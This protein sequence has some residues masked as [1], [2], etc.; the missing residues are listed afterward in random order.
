MVRKVAFLTSL[1]ALLLLSWF[2][3]RE[4]QRSVC[5]N[6]KLVKKI[7]IESGEGIKEVFACP[8]RSR[9]SLSR[10]AQKR[11]REISA[12]T[13]NLDKMLPAAAKGERFD[14]LVSL[15]RPVR[16]D[17]D[18]GQITVGRDLFW[19][20]GQ[21]ERAIIK[22]VLMQ[23][24]HANLQKNLFY[25]E[26]IVDLLWTII[27]GAPTSQDPIFQEE[28]ADLGPKWIHYLRS[29]KSVCRSKDRPLGLIS[30]C[31]AYE[32]LAEEDAEFSRNILEGASPWGFRPFLRKVF[33]Q[34]FS[35]RPMREMVPFWRHWV[36]SLLNKNWPRAH[37][38]VL[39]DLEDVQGFL[40][41][42]LEETLKGLDSSLGFEFQSLLEELEVAPG[43]KIKVPF[44]LTFDP[45]DQSI[46]EWARQSTR[47]RAR[48]KSSLFLA[49]SGDQLFVF[50]TLFPVKVEGA[51]GLLAPQKTARQGCGPWSVAELLSQSSIEAKI[52]LVEKCDRKI[53]PD[54]VSFISEG[55]GAFSQVNPQIAFWS[56]N[57]RSLKMGLEWG[58]KESDHFVFTGVNRKLTKV[59]KLMGFDRPAYDSDRN[60][61]KIS[62][63]LPVIDWYRATSGRKP[64]LMRSKSL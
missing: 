55:L 54:Y 42:T 44:L 41:V 4:S 59:E 29:H 18:R 15:R 28:T 27:S 3:G 53:F 39:K 13:S 52:L 50:P 7:Q 30:T 60:A 9:E 34:V 43:Q 31:E 1:F 64:L 48:D 17:V 36:D 22:R 47:L 10:A 57:M 12:F 16:L 19:L 11:M 56:L 35:E 25:Q 49:Y 37:W 5:I 33:W 38:G 26:V 2:T 32:L 21:L 51:L 63:A 24:A 62:G 58:V 61:Y 14:I 45:E 8:E 40:R 20:K 46:L 23:E 6:S